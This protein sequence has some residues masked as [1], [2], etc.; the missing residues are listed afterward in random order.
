MKKTIFFMAFMCSL[1]GFSQNKK[2]TISSIKLDGIVVSAQRF[3]KPK[4]KLT[5]QVESVSKIEIETG[6]FQTSPDVLANS[7][8]VAVQKSQQGGGSPNIRGF[9]ASRI[10]LVVDGIRMNNLIYRAGHLQ[11]SISVAKNIL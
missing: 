10:L 4:R 2:D 6:N 3:A 7:G 8:I 9:E 11:N 5:Q 1:T